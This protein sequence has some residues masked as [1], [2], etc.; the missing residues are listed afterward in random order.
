VGSVAEPPT[1]R[2]R[3]ARVIYD[4]RERLGTI[5]QLGDEFIARDR[6]GQIIG[7]FDTAIDATN[8]VGKTVS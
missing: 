1:K 4:G 7:R 6:R 5:E 8:A 3:P 2:K